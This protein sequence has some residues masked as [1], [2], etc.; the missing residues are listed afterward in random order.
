MAKVEFE[1]LKQ[2]KLI[3]RE[4]RFVAQVQLAEKQV[5]TYVPNPGRM[6][7]LMVPGTEVYVYHVAQKDRKTEYNLALVNYQ[8]HLVSINSQLPNQLI[9][10]ALEK[11]ELSPYEDYTEIKAEHSF[12]N[13]RLD[14]YLPG[15]EEVLIEVKSVTLVE[16]K[17]AKFPDAPTK[18]GRRHLGELIEAVNQGYRAGVVFVIQRDDAQQFEPHQRID[19]KFAEKLK[20]AQE[21]GVEIYA[22]NCKVDL[23]GIAIKDQVVVE[24]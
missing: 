17:I 22:W 7:E 16:E 21:A 8:D 3:E 19:L 14:F 23:E 24:V 5:K 18:R 1:N 6:E 13:S 20:E 10:K 9:L 15:A 2:G 12:G 11:Q 4:N